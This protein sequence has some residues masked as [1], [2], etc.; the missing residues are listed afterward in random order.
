MKTDKSSSIRNLSLLTPCEKTVEMLK[1]L[2]ENSDYYSLFFIDT[3]GKIL[4]CNRKAEQLTGYSSKELAGKPYAFLFPEEEINRNVPQQMLDLAKAHGG[5]ERDHRRARKDDCTL[6]VNSI[7]NAIYDSND[8]FVGYGEIARE[9]LGEKLEDVDWQKSVDRFRSVS[10]MPNNWVWEVDAN[11]VYTYCSQ[12]VRDIFHYQPEEILGRKPSDFLTPEDGAALRAVFYQAIVNKAP[13]RNLEIRTANKEGEMLC[14]RTNG[15]PYFGENGELMGY[16]GINHDVTQIKEA[17]ANLTEERLMLKTLFASIPDL[18]WLK[19]P[20]G[21][22]LTCNPKFELL[23]GAKEADIVGKTDYDFVSKEVADAFREKD[24]EAVANNRSSANLEWVTYADDGHKEYLE[25]VKTPMYDAAGNLVGVLGIARDI[26]EHK[27]I[28]DALN[29]SRRQLRLA[30]DI[31]GLMSWE[32]DIVNDR[33]TFDDR[34]YILYGM[35]PEKEALT[36]CYADYIGKYVYPDD[37]E[38]VKEEI[39]KVNTSDDP[40]FFSQLEHR[41]VR[42]DGEIRHIVVRYKIHVDENGVPIRTYGVN[43][44]ITDMKQ[45]EIELRELNAS[46]DRFFSIVAHDL[47]SPFNTFLGYT[48]LMAEEFYNMNLNDIKMMAAELRK[49][50]GNLFNLL[51]NL[52]EWS[53]LERGVAVFEPMPLSLKVKVA[54]SVQLAMDLAAK[55]G[56]DFSYDI[57]IDLVVFADDR[58][59]KSMVRN[60]TSNALKFTKRGGK[61]FLVAR[62]IDGFAEVAVSDTGIG[63]SNELMDKLFRIDLNASRVGTEGELSSGLG[64]I[65]CKEFQDKQ[66]GRIWVESEEGK[67]ST[68]RFTLPLYNG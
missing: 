28:E 32:Y 37:V 58:M 4:S 48:E 65:L 30:M 66:G 52:L 57:P 61:V 56:I 64:L 49:S 45:K 17:E 47:R 46:K 24:R 54:E 62:P 7:V 43:Q 41:I 50:A 18:I 55:K 51:E 21:V 36:M 6:L 39:S 14:F 29:E 10:L 9:I 25:T 27:Q 12:G 44:D 26:T 20:D 19:N 13:L 59:L 63:M 34:F 8:V 60:L 22:Y 2:T 40:D 38:Y 5:T 3:E 35:S 23:Y 33:F 1:M 16:R 42:G 11:G 31:G 68:F 53:R 67:G 15:I